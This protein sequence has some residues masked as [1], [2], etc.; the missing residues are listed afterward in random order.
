MKIQCV[1]AFERARVD[2]AFMLRRD[3]FGMYHSEHKAELEEHF[4]SYN[5]IL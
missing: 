3:V 4:L 2:G 1:H 5:W